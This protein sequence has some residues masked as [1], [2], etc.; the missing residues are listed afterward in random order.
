MKWTQ[1]LG[2]VDKGSI[3]QSSLLGKKYFEN[4]FGASVFLERHSKIHCT[5][6]Y[7]ERESKSNRTLRLSLPVCKASNAWRRIIYTGNK[8]WYY[9]LRWTLPSFQR[10]MVKVRGRRNRRKMRKMPLSSGVCGSPSCD[11]VKEK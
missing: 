2:H 4:I 6:S 1:T 7:C 8:D 9:Y 5:C 3:V 11:C 10:W